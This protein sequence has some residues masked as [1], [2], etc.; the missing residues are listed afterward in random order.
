MIMPA[1]ILQIHRFGP[2]LWVRLAQSI[3]AEGNKWSF[4]FQKLH[5]IDEPAEG[6]TFNAIPKQIVVRI[7]ALSNFQG[8]M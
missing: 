5:I 3:T 4:L 1:L 7:V 2:S 6:H 8:R